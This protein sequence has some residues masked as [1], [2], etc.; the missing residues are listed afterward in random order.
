MRSYLIDA[1]ADI[2]Y[3]LY[4]DNDSKVY[5]EVD[6]RRSPDGSLTPLSFVWEDGRRFSVDRVVDIRPA[7]SLKAGGAGMRYGVKIMGKDKFMFLE[8]EG[9]VERWFMERK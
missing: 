2:D 5:V 7:A 9:G 1:G 4:M 8:E 6:E 3:K